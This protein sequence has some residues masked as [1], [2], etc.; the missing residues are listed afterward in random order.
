MIV[1]IVGSAIHQS[2]CWRKNKRINRESWDI[3]FFSH[4]YH[5]KVESV[6]TNGAWCFA[7]LK[8]SKQNKTTVQR[9][10]QFSD[11]NLSSYLY[12]SSWKFERNPRLTT[13]YLSN[14]SFGCTYWIVSW[15]SNKK[16]WISRSKMS[17]V[18]KYHERQRMKII[19]LSF[20][21]KD[22]TFNWE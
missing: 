8:D 18:W 17:S 14:Q 19:V 11:F 5:L 2:W 1:C 12:I 6:P 3:L 10:S 7:L 20:I 21:G 9:S 15:S 4:Y 13:E 16:S 22:E